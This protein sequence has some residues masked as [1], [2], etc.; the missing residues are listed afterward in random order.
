MATSCEATLS[1]LCPLHTA[2][3]EDDMFCCNYILNSNLQRGQLSQAALLSKVTLIKNLSIASLSLDYGFVI[4]AVITY[5][6]VQQRTNFESAKMYTLIITSFGSF[7]DVILTFVVVGIIDQNHLVDVFAELYAHNC[8]TEDTD[9]LL[10][11]FQSQFE[12]ILTLDALEGSLDIIGLLLLIIGYMLCEE[13]TLKNYTEGIHGFIFVIFDLVVISVNVFQFVLPAYG[14]FL[15][16][17]NGAESLCFQKIFTDD[18]NTYDVFITTDGGWFVGAD[19]DQL[20]DLPPLLVM[21]YIFVGI[22]MILFG[23][24]CM[25]KLEDKQCPHLCDGHLAIWAC[26]AVIIIFCFILLILLAP[27]L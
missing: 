19:S 8:Y 22:F 23:F 9:L 16:V 21:L 11:E 1:E 5:F 10:I 25:V 27:Y 24:I 2:L 12:S 6:C 20:P 4:I 15:N 7:L 14:A 3:H 17:Y 13:P 26:M 18:H